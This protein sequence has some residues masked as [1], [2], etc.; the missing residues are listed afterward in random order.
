MHHPKPTHYDVLWCSL[1]GVLGLGALRNWNIS[2][3]APSWRKSWWHVEKRSIHWMWLKRNDEAW[4]EM[5]WSQSGVD[6][7]AW[8]GETD[9]GCTVKTIEKKPPPQIVCTLFWRPLR[10]CDINCG[11]FSSECTHIIRLFS[12]LSWNSSSGKSNSLGLTRK[13]DSEYTP[14]NS[15]KLENIIRQKG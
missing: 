13:K 5:W 10:P 1:Y 12:N 14:G 3:Q 11:E 2:K 15:Q 8:P 9:V 6:I 7:E 4:L